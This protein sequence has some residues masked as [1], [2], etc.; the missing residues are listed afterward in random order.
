MNMEKVSILSAQRTKDWQRKKE[1]VPTTLQVN[2]LTH[3]IMNQLTVVYLSCAK[4]R[5]RPEATPRANED[6]E[7]IETAV[8][9]IALQVEAL[10]FRLEKTAR[11]RPKPSLKKPHKRPRPGAKLSVISGRDIAKR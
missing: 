6:I 2:R 4:L 5:R 7:T 10:R 9:K 11:V 1:A 8:A 3:S